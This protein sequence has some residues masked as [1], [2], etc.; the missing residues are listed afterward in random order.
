MTTATIE[1]HHHRLGVLRCTIAGA[2]VL[3]VQFVLC[4]IGA[5]FI[6]SQTHMF[7]ELFTAQPVASTAALG[8]GTIWAGV[9]GAI[10]GF[11]VAVIYNVLASL[12]RR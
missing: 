7:V 12:D 5:L 10:T 4:W 2:L 11:L 8:I 1:T 3:A 9:F 6:A